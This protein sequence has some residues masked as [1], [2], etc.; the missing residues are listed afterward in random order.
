MNSLKLLT[1]LLLCISWI[2]A[3]HK[4]CGESPSIKYRDLAKTLGKWI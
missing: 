1:L 4:E 2:S 3:S